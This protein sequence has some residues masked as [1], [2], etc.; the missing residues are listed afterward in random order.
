M[1]KLRRYLFT[2]F[3]SGIGDNADLAWEDA[4][5]AFSQDYGPTPDESQYE[6]SEES[7]EEEAV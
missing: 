3:I 5:E 4:C 2:I 6:Y 1:T 7:D